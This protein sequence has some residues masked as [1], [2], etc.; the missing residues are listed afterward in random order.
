MANVRR[1][2]G[3]DLATI[4]SMGESMRNESPRFARLGYSYERVFELLAGLSASPHG[5]VLVAEQDGEIV[6]ML[7]GFVGKHFF[8]DDLTANELVVYVA[9]Q[10]RGGTASVKLI[11]YFESWA[12]QLGVAD[13][14]LGVSTEVHAERT[15]EF[16][17][18]LG[19]APSGITLVK[20]CA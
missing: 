10:A 8:S 5:L 13:I 12:K 11:R 1:A 15:A 3:S 16:Y 7:L 19:Y 6:G 20:R 14:T 17:Q 4:V 9:P 18:R 2:L